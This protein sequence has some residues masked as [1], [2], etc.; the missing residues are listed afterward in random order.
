MQR[1]SCRVEIQNPETL[2]SLNREAF[3]KLISKLDDLNWMTSKWYS[4]YGDFLK[5]I[6][7]H[8][9]AN[10]KASYQEV[11]DSCYHDLMKN[12]YRSDSTK[13]AITK[14]FEIEEEKFSTYDYGLL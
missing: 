9:S 8:L 3:I 12:I 5:S 7:Y 10:P 13:E 4:E 6:V 2:K 14:L 11:V 1:S